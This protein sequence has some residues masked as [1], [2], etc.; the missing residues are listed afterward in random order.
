[1]FVWSPKTEYQTKLSDFFSLICD[2][3]PAVNDITMNYLG[4]CCFDGIVNMHYKLAILIIFLPAQ[5]MLV[6]WM[7]YSP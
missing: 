6:V 5:V 2:F 4:L 7:E 1:M 3:Q